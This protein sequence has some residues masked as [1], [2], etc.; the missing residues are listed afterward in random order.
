MSVRRRN[1]AIRRWSA[2]PDR[3]ALCATPVGRAAAAL[4][5]F[6]GTLVVITHDRALLDAL[7]LTRRLVVEDG[8]IVADDTN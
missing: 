6:A 4:D 1:L 7:R 2:T 8:S 5:R 3:P